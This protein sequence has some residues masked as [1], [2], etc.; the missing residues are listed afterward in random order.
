VDVDPTVIAAS[1][2]VE[3]V[4]VLIEAERSPMPA[5]EPTWVTTTLTN[6]GPGVLHWLTDAC[7][8]HV[9]VGG[10]MSAL[11]WA[12]GTEQNGAARTFKSWANQTIVEL[13][14]PITLRFVPERWAG[15][16]IDGCA[17]IGIGHELGVGRRVVQRHQ[18]DGFTGDFGLPPSGPAE[19]TAT[20][21]YWWREGEPEG[22]GPDV[23]ATLPVLIDKG[24]GPAELSP[25]QVIDRALAVPQFR[26]VLEAHPSLQDW[27]MPI[28]VEF[29]PGT[30]VWQVELR[31]LDGTSAL[32]VMDAF[33]GVGSVQIAP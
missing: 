22:S 17:D 31:N 26:A 5:G 10:R 15:R 2:T 18:W 1:N 9:G 16:G 12:A 19:L 7:E 30:G 14:G 13:G 32:V 3:G 6:E 21:D 20:F 11:R 23:A 24:R 25:G 27:D 33:G 4:R 8:T 28:R 29:D